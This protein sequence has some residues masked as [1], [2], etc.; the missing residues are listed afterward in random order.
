G[1]ALLIVLWSPLPFYA[2]SLSY[3]WVP[4]HVPM[5]WPHAVFNQRF[6]LELLPLFAVSAGLLV[7]LIFAKLRQSSAWSAVGTAA[8]LIVVSYGFVLKA[9]PLCLV[10][11]ERSW[12]AR[13]G[14][15]TS[16]ERLL[17]ALPSDSMFLMDLSEHVGIM[18]RAGIPLRRV[19]NSENH[20]PW[21]RPTDPQG[22]WERALGDPAAYVNYV[23]AFEGD[24]VDRNVNRT[25]LTLLTVI[26]SLD[27]PPARIYQ[28]ARPVNQPR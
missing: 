21:V 11:A 16:V 22:I 7:A 26:H 9:Q 1:L 28:T 17:K 6:G 14:I 10:E 19:V 25:N 20:R 5:W 2:Y 27:Q 12:N 15:D 4:L 24:P 3:G 18:E 13:R 8:I 23:I